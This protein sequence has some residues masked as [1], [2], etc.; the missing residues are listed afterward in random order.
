MCVT[1]VTCIVSKTLE[2]QE[3]EVIIFADTSLK[4]GVI[5]QFDHARV[6]VNKSSLGLGMPI[7]LSSN[8][9][10]TRILLETGLNVWKANKGKINVTF[11]VAGGKTVTLSDSNLLE[12]ETLISHMP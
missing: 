6:K 3:S 9:T 11:R 10:N 5:K 4:E 2:R 7:R 8:E 1:P 12:I